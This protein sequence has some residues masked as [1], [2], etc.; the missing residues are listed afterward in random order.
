[1]LKVSENQKIYIEYGLAGI[2]LLLSSWCLSVYLQMKPALLVFVILSA[3][4]LLGYMFLKKIR[5]DRRE[6]ISLLGFSAV[7]DAVLILG[8]HIHTED[9]YTGTIKNNYILPY[10]FADAAALVMMLPC[11]MIIFSALY[12]ACAKSKAVN[13]GTYDENPQYRRQLI[14]FAVLFCLWIPYLLAYWPGIILGD[15]LG[16][17][18][19]ALGMARLH[20][21]HPV[22]HTFLVSV[23]MN[24]GKLLFGSL[25]AG[26]AIYTVL[27]MLYVSFGL[28]YILNWVWRHGR[29]CAVIS[30]IST[31]MFGLYPYF[32]AFSTAG[33]KDPIF[34]VS[35]AMLSVYL[36]ND[37]MH[38]VPKKTVKS[39][40]IYVL[41][42]I[43][44]AFSRNNGIG[45]LAFVA[46]WQLAEQ[47]I[48]A[49]RQKKDFSHVLKKTF[50]QKAL[51]T[52]IVCA[53]NF[54]LVIPVFYI[55]GIN[56]DMREPSGLIMQQMARVA[57]VG[58]N[59]SADEQAYLGSL[60][61]MEL[62]AE[63][64]RPCCV[65]LFKWDSNFNTEAVSPVMYKHW[66]T[67]MLKN[68]ITYFEAWM[69]NSHG[70]WTLNVPSINAHY[71][72][73][74]GGT[75]LNYDP[76]NIGLVH[77]LGME[78]S[79]LF[80]NDAV[81]KVLVTDIWFIPVGWVFWAAVFL[82]LCMILKKQKKLLGGMMPT[83]GLMIPIIIG[84]PICY[85]MRY[86]FAIHYLIPVYIMLFLVSAKGAQSA[87]AES[88]K[89]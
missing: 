47:F 16:S 87:E 20:N 60:F 13:E 36:L 8:Y 53:V 35:V 33:W 58:G 31:A 54:I 52:V 67:L 22:M 19:Q 72:N 42:L 12:K 69:M 32:A 17:L 18:K 15:T 44:V 6:S 7:V 75:I 29:V 57:A 49:R 10:S 81:R 40:V 21:N 11:L 4:S 51:A 43:A 50:S 27:Q 84:T 3:V 66:F 38:P 34:S 9:A 46:V 85:W 1:M 41:L 82:C 28:S 88:E 56:I 78:C 14:I 48:K 63:G 80:G 39:Y 62:Y 83:L 86:A 64:Y 74:A 30:I 61:P 37:A 71:E 76:D 5:I 23:C 2:I 73:I 24:L 89:A 55:I 45:V 68:P 70:F 25:T 65:D 77:A 79:N 26:Y 59:M